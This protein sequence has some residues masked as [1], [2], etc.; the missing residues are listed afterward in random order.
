MKHAR[1]P[2]DRGM[3]LFLGGSVIALA[4]ACGSSRP[5][6]VGGEGFTPSTGSGPC[7]DGQERPCGI[8]LR[9]H[10]GVAD[11]IQATQVCHGGGWG[12]CGEKGPV[13]TL[14]IPLSS[15]ATDDEGPST[16]ALAPAP[17]TCKDNPCNPYCRSF[18][19]TVPGVLDAGAPDGLVYSDG[20]AGITVPVTTTGSV[21]GGAVIG[22]GDPFGGR[23]NVNGPC[24]TNADCNVDQFC[25]KTTGKCESWKPG[26]FNDKCVQPPTTYGALK[27]KL[28]CKFVDKADNFGEFTGSVVVGQFDKSFANPPS[29]VA[30]ATL[31]Q[32]DATGA[33]TQE[34]RRGGKIKM[35]DAKACALDVSIPN[36]AGKPAD[37]DGGTLRFESSSTPLLVDLND[38]GVPE[39]VAY[40]AVDSTHL[41]SGFYSGRLV[42]FSVSVSATGV[43]TIA[44][45]ASWVDPGGV[46]G[47]AWQVSKN[48]A[49]TYAARLPLQINLDSSGPSAIDLDNDGRP[50]I[51]AN[52]YV[53]NRQGRLIG[54]R[55]N[56]FG[57]TAVQLGEVWGSNPVVGDF[58]LDGKVEL[59]ETQGLFEA[60]GFTYTTGVLTGMT[61][62]VDSLFA[63]PKD[64]SGN[65]VPS[66][67][68]TQYFGKGFQAF[69]DFGAYGSASAADK[70]ELVWVEGNRARVMALDGSP[71]FGFNGV[72]PATGRAAIPAGFSGDVPVPG[73]GGGGITIADYDGDGLPEFGVAGAKYY[74]VFDLDC[75]SPRSY[76]GKTGTCNRAGAA[77]D[78]LAAG[79]CTG[80]GPDTLCQKGVLW[81]RHTQ[82][83]TSFV[84]G[85]SVFDFN[86]D[87]RAEV[88][89]GDECWTRVYDGQT[90]RVV[91][92]ANHSSG[93]WLEQPT[94]ADVDLDGRADLVTASA[95]VLE[96][97]PGRGLFCPFTRYT[98]TYTG[99]VGSN[100]GFAIGTLNVAWVPGTITVYTP[101]PGMQVKLTKG[102]TTKTFTAN[103]SGV[104]TMSF[105]AGEAGAWTETGLISWYTPYT[106]YA[107]FRM[108]HMG[109]PL[110]GSTEPARNAGT[111]TGEGTDALF[112]GLTCGTS[113]DCPNTTMACTAGLCR[114]TAD[115]Q[116][117]SGFKCIDPP[118][119]TGGAKTC[120]AT[121]SY[122][123]GG[124]ENG[125]SVYSGPGS[126]WALSRYTWNQQAYT[127]ATIQDNAKVKSTSVCTADE[128][129]AWT[130]ANPQ[131]NSFRQQLQ[132][133]G[134]SGKG[135]PDLTLQYPCVENYIPVCNRGAGTAPPGVMVVGFPGNST[136]FEGDSDKAV[137]VGP[138]YT[139]APLAPGE[140]VNL[141]CS[142]A[143]KGTEEYMINPSCTSGKICTT[144]ADCGGATCDA[145]TSRCPMTCTKSGLSSTPAIPECPGGSSGWSFVHGSASKA[146]CGGG[147]SAS[148]AVFTRDFVAACPVGTRARWGMFT[149]ETAAPSGT[150]IEFRFSTA[151]DAAG[152]V[153]ATKTLVAR[154][155]FFPV[156][157]ATATT[158]AQVCLKT[159]TPACFRDL[160]VLV[161]PADQPVLRMEATLNPDTTTGA[162][163]VLNG[164]NVTFD[165][166]PSE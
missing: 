153:A 140:C 59:I 20:G 68:P 130:P 164:W 29:M 112:P 143:G 159:S 58:D 109:T 36:S 69:A 23:A 12:E 91:F 62:N 26:A 156:G 134:S 115:A 78:C 89:Y 133:P 145:S 88:V 61:W 85:S 73:G 101:Y 6:G 132:Y 142:G 151:A 122:A 80:G 94:I 98:A 44:P 72:T 46:V 24:T 86:A 108:D 1:V 165:C 99:N 95:R 25:N 42:A 48:S 45:Y 92:S 96:A 64:A 103:A 49:G 16:K 32:Y 13:K 102:A 74:T 163:P 118:A 161:A 117:G 125:I 35:I 107:S 149:Y 17:S 34:D 87:G 148:P 138:C 120:R 51:I 131:E 105:A 104:V 113:A 116:C 41:G 10:D 121:K 146:A 152:L 38:D 37:P 100:Y 119:S 52:G 114:C 57:L 166:L 97:S 70:P 128:A 19:D 135:I 106:V 5:D 150:N 90:G 3:R 18:P 28:G 84:T 79:D 60:G 40:T 43:Y 27:P 157:S 31:S 136:K 75:V 144:S 126:G 15:V 76:K 137:K 123:A 7:A 162:A 56:R 11:C 141:F 63:F 147:V 124:G 14:S 22:P 53:F 71:V 65:A 160:S 81:S 82:D 155:G 111:A 158:D 93:T 39:I 77:C 55:P 21:D 50:E 8:T 127:P 9:T 129:K 47:R 154:P 110:A 67:Q 83:Q 66:D 2:R 33:L 54:A 139:T 30:I 4:I